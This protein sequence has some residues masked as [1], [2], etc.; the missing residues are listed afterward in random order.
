LNI[1]QQAGTVKYQLMNEWAENLFGTGEPEGLTR[2]PEMTWQVD[3]Q[4]VTAPE[5]A[6][7]LADVYVIGGKYLSDQ[8]LPT[9]PVVQL[10]YHIS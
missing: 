8:A 7:Y 9:F 4:D 5:L 3:S 6:A 2:V 10:L 1:D